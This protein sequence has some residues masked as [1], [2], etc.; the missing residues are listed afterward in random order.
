MSIEICIYKKN[1]VFVT[2]AYRGYKRLV[3]NIPTPV[4]ARR[5]QA[6]FDTTLKKKQ[7]ALYAEDHDADKPEQLMSYHAHVFE[8]INFQQIK[9]P[10]DHI[11]QQIK[12]IPD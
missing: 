6:W 9:W 8:K 7:L 2:R 11:F 3:L 4:C 12:N 1:H 5:E 10:T